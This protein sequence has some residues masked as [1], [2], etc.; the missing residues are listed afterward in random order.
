[1]STHPW[2]QSMHRLFAFAIVASLAF[3]AISVASDGYR[4]TGHA[5]VMHFISVEPAQKNNEDL[6]RLAVAEAC[7]GKAICQVHFWVGDAPSALPMSDAQVEA[8]L[9]HWQQNLNTG[10]RRWL[11]KCSTGTTLFEQERECM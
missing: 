11:V 10:L 1:M 8:K 7:A 9:V 4:V 3:P 6:Y 5:G 2:G